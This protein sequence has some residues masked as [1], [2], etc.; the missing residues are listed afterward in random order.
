MTLMLQH[1]GVLI[2]PVQTAPPPPLQAAILPAIQV[3]PPLPTVGPSSSPLRPVTL[4]FSSSVISSVSTQPLVP[5][6]PIVTTAAV[7]VSVTSSALAAPAAQPPSE[8]VP[9][10]ASTSD[11]GSE[12]DSDP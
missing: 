3:G 10:P 1:T 6:A 11:P 9:A 2:P 7:V 12:T 4:V 5:P 8:S